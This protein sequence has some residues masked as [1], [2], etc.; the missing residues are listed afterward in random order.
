MIYVNKNTSTSQEDESEQKEEQPKESFNFSDMIYRYNFKDHE[1]PSDVADFIVS[2]ANKQHQ[3]NVLGRAIL[4][5]NHTATN[6][7]GM[8]FQGSAQKIINAPTSS[9]IGDYY[10]INYDVYTDAMIGQEIRKNG[11]LNDDNSINPID[12]TELRNRTAFE[13]NNSC[14]NIEENIYKENNYYYK[15][16]YVDEGYPGY[17]FEEEKAD[18]FIG[19]LIDDLSSSIFSQGKV[20]SNTYGH[21]SE[22]EFVYDLIFERTEE[23]NIVSAG[24]SYL[25]IDVGT[26]Q[27]SLFFKIVDGE[28]VFNRLLAANV[29]KSNYVNDFYFGEFKTTTYARYDISL[30]HDGERKAYEDK[31]TLV[32]SF[33][34]VPAL[35]DSHLCGSAQVDNIKNLDLEKGTYRDSFVYLEYPNFHAEMEDGNLF[36]IYE[37]PLKNTYSDYY[38]FKISPSFTYIRMDDPISIEQSF[39][40][41]DCFLTSELGLVS[42]DLEIT[43]CGGNE[44][45]H[46]TDKTKTSLTAKIKITIDD[47]EN[48][49]FTYQV[50]EATTK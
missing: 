24:K 22:D 15:N 40:K 43:D 45:F 44:L 21:L 28:Y 6:I 29:M 5:G 33:P 49:E 25:G 35:L 17:D 47:Y 7:S 12:Q 46:L 32:S 27:M 3:N 10:A 4:K 39:N 14:F 11:Y 38:R 37:F 8:T 2:L 18:P 41:K 9:I 36:F 48:K 34:V 20:V 23:K 1:G 50:V 16:C 42:D 31:D 26:A 30:K 13:H 19:D